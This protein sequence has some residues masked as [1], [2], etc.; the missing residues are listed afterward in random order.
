MGEE[1]QEREQVAQDA[2]ED[3]ELGDEAAG[4]V[5]GGAKTADKARLKATFSSEPIAGGG[6]PEES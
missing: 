1:A 6:R 5:T 2:A 4:A 3:L